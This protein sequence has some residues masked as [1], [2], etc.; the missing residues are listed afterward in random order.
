[1]QKQQHYSFAAI[2]AAIFTVAVATAAT[3]AAVVFHLQ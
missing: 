2:S 1:M 3:T